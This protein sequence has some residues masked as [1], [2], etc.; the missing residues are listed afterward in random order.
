MV[1]CRESLTLGLMHDVYA[2]SNTDC[3]CDPIWDCYFQPVRQ[4]VN[5]LRPLSGQGGFFV[6]GQGVF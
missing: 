5:R 1:R 3:Y 2:F 4:D 6:R